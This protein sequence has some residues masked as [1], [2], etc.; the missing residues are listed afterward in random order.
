[1]AVATAL[2]LRPIAA[3]RQ[4]NPLKIPKLIDGG[5]DARR[6]YEL[7]VAAG[8]S[9]FLPDLPTPTLGINGAYLGPTIRVRAGD[10]VTLRVKKQY[11]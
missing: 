9:N 10:R 2:P 8:I 5:T 1:M 4:T 3:E 7:D 6:T 11:G